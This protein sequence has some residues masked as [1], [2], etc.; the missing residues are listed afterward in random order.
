MDDLSSDL[1]NVNDDEVHIIHTRPVSTI[2]T[3][4]SL[5]NNNAQQ[6]IS[7][8]QEMIQSLQQELQRKNKI[9]EASKN[10]TYMNLM[11]KES[12]LEEV[13]LELSAKRKEEKEL[14]GKEKIN[15]NQI[16]TLEAQTDR[17]SVV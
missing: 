1:D 6:E 15:L 9:I 17:K 11:E 2:S 16:A 3:T 4:R 14:R 10:D 8:L 7:A 13:K 12:Q 5:S